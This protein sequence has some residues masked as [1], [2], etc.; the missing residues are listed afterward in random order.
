MATRLHN[1]DQKIND[2]IREAEQMCERSVTDVFNA[3]DQERF[4]AIETDVKTLSKQRDRL[5]EIMM[6]GSTSAIERV[7][8]G[9]HG[10]GPTLW[11]QNSGDSLERGSEWAA[12]ETVIANAHR[13]AERGIVELDDKYRAGIDATLRSVHGDRVAVARHIIATGR[14]EYRSGWQKMLASTLRGLPP[15]DLTGDEIEAINQVRAASLTDA[16]GGYAV[17]VTLDPTLI[18]TGAHDGELSQWRQLA[19][20]KTTA[21]DTW[22]GVQSAGVTAHWYGEAQEI[23]DDSPTLTSPTITPKKASAFIPFSV[24]VQGDW[25]AMESDL[26]MMLQVAKDDLE[27]AAFASA[28]AITNGPDGLF[29]GLDGTS[30]EVSPTTPETFAIADLYKLIGAVPARYRSNGSFLADYATYGAIRQFDTAGGSALWA[31]LAADRPAILLGRPAYEEPL[32]RSTADI[33]TAVTA[34]NFILVFG[35]FARGFYIVDRVGMSVELISHLFHTANNR[36]SLQRGLISWW[37]TG[38]KVVDSS[39]LA[40]LNVATTA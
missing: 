7:A 40:V 22:N 12:P 24:E 14:E 18:L 26:R 33:N 30:A 16:S 20:V 10:G 27:S 31:Q 23:S 38:S 21:T 34:D 3:A 11:R 29:Y 8:D 39:A 5:K 25:A 15:T 6:A 4:N 2:L 32:M 28:V 17:P 13:A 19:T 36:P 37:R 9:M 1:I 35:D